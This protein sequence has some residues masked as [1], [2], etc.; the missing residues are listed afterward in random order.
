MSEEQ[1]KNQLHGI[2]LQ[3]V[4]EELV[5]RRGWDNLSQEIKIRC[6]TYDPSIK[7]TL[8]FLRRTPWARKA[9]E[10]LFLYDRR[11]LQRAKK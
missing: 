7:S 5:E 6:F 10:E 4:V 2:T 11:V 3:A 8:K 9:V 1:P